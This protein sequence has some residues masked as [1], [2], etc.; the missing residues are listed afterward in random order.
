MATQPTRIGM[1]AYTRASACSDFAYTGA[2]K[3]YKGCLS[4]LAGEGSIS[5]VGREGRP[6][7][8]VGHRKGGWIA[9]GGG[10]QR[11]Q[12]VVEGVG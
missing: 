5:L 10:G 9:I 11:G 8:V 2:I 6:S 4:P 3:R 12:V 1:S 7:K